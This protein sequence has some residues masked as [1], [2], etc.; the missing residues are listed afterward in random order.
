MVKSGDTKLVANKAQLFVT[1]H[2]CPVLD[3]MPSKKLKTVYV[4]FCWLCS[5]NL[6]VMLTV[7]S[8]VDVP[9]S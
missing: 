9:F 5:Q 1:L 8:I 7:E 2:L 4:W 6:C 3:K